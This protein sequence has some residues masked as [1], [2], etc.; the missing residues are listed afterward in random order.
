[1][2]LGWDL[3]LR[4]Q[5]TRDLDHDTPSQRFG[6]DQNYAILRHPFFTGALS[7]F[8]QSKT[9]RAHFRFD[10]IGPRYDLD[11]T[12]RSGGSVLST[13]KPYRELGLGLAYVPTSN[14]LLA[15]RGEHLLQPRQS[16]QDWL[17]GR[18]DSNGDATLVYGFPAPGPRW[19]LTAT[20]RW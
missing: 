14:L 18:T 13:G 12:G 15:L 8:I 20:W 5:E 1:V 17:S 10:R 3:M 6:S 7:G 16:V 11:D 4:S 9:W 2:A 19:T